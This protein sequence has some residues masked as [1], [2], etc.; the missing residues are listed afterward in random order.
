MRG[1]RQSVGVFMAVP[2]R[3]SAAMYSNP[4]SRDSKFASPAYEP[5]EG[6]LTWD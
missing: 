6:N 1:F 3:S 5:I 4:L 2:D